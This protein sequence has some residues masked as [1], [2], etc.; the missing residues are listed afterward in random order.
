MVKEEAEIQGRNGRRNGIVF[1]GN[2]VLSEIEGAF[3]HD[4]S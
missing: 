2:G 3:H 1:G 4:L